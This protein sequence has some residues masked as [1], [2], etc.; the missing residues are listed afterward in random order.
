MKSWQ[1][2]LGDTW[3]DIT[4]QFGPRSQALWSAVEVLSNTQWFSRVGK[5]LRG[6][7][8]ERASSWSAALELFENTTH[9]V[10]G[11][12]AAPVERIWHV[13]RDKRYSGWWLRA[14]EA[15]DENCNYAGF[16][17]K[18][19]PQESQDLLWEH[20]YTYLSLL[21]AEVIAGDDL[22]CT[23][24]R[25]QLAFYAKGHFPCGWNGDWPN[26]RHRVF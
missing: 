4:D 7:D 24:F 15:A 9:D 13:T 25:E 12:L 16:I 10:K 17:P 14:R 8:I 19:L 20:L 26:G 22:G 2:L 6:V 5:P 1:E 18:T 11:H 23:Y 21:L 3:E